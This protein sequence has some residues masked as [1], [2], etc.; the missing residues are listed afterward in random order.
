MQ[1]YTVRF[2][3]TGVPVVTPEGA[4]RAFEVSVTLDAT[5]EE[6]AEARARL[7]VYREW[8]S[9]GWGAEAS[10][11]LPDL[12]VIALERVSSLRAPFTAKGVGDIAPLHDG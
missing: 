1:L 7:D 11:A 2:R 3:G 10:G 8:T 9:R 6:A 12:A 4:V 5:G